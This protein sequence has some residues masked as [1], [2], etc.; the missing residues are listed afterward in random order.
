MGKASPD[1]LEPDPQ[2]PNATAIAE[3]AATIPCRKTVLQL[4]SKVVVN[5]S[6]LPSLTRLLLSLTTMPVFVPIPVIY[7]KRCASQPANPNPAL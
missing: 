3:A 2:P 5:I 6:F 7:I 1:E 4:I